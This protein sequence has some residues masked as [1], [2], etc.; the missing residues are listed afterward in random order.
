MIIP[1]QD[2]FEDIN[3]ND[4]DA[5]VLIQDLAYWLVR[6][7]DVTVRRRKLDLLEKKPG[8]LSGFTPTIIFVKMLQRAVTFSEESTKYAIQKLRPKFNDA[9]NDATSKRGLRIL[10]INSCNSFQHYDHRGNL[11]PAGK[12]EFWWEL[13]ELINRFDLNK[14]KLMPNPKNPPR[15]GTKPNSIGGNN[16]HGSGNRRPLP[17]P[18]PA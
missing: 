8:V 7:I 5:D 15:N 1:D 6:K 3:L 18:P 16:T 9:L 4:K 2:I 13:D 14:I 11:S 17:P 10:T 12:H